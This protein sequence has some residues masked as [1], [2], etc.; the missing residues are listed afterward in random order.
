M[1]SAVAVVALAL[2]LSQPSVTHAV[3]APSGVN[4]GPWGVALGDLNKDGQQDIVVATGGGN[5]IRPLLSNGSALD[6]YLPVKVVAINS[7][8][9]A[10]VGG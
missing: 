2:G 5:T 4:T 1:A 3:P 8:A 7:V 10:A 9:L 6:S